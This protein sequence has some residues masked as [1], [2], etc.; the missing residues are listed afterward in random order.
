M[1]CDFDVRYSISGWQGAT[2]AGRSEILIKIYY[3]DIGMAG[4]HVFPARNNVS[5]QGGNQ[6]NKE[7]E[8]D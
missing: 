8:S 1:V 2:S 5:E 3:E 6:Q 7:V 4:F